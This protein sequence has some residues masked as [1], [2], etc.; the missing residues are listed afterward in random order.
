MDPKIAERIS[1]KMLSYIENYSVLAIKK[2]KRYKNG[3]KLVSK[4]YAHHAACFAKAYKDVHELS[5]Y[6]D[7]LITLK[8]IRLRDT[9]YIDPDATSVSSYNN[10]VSLEPEQVVEYMDQLVEL[11]SENNL[12][13]KLIKTKYDKLDA[14]HV[15][16]KAENINAY[17]IKWILA[18]I[19]YMTESP[20]SWALREAFTLRKELPELKDFP[21]LSILIFIWSTVGTYHA[22]S[23][24][25]G[26]Y[27]YAPL[28]FPTLKK[29]IYKPF[30]NTWGVDRWFYMYFPNKQI[31][32]KWPA[33]NANEICESAECQRFRHFPYVRKYVCMDQIPEK[34][35]EYYKKMFDTVKD[36]IK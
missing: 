28:T 29:C 4:I 2:D 34:M 19:R 7:S 25:A 26:A 21:L 33:T 13:Y 15:I 16:V 9:V 35:I 1:T 20:C 32:D 14:L 6:S 23:L 31:L 17:Y 24:N 30:R 18:Y 3:G 22:L 36:K 12:S 11:F 27:I 10:F 8:S 5:Y